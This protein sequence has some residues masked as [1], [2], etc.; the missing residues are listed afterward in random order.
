M[1]CS[2]ESAYIIDGLY[3]FGDVTAD[4]CRLVDLN[5]I[6]MD[7]L[8]DHTEA[9][10]LTT[11]TRR[12]ELETASTFKQ[13]GSPDAV[14]AALAGLLESDSQIR[15]MCLS[16]SLELVDSYCRKTGKSQGQ[17]LQTTHDFQ[18][19]QLSRRTDIRRS[20]NIQCVVNSER[21]SNWRARIDRQYAR[22]RQVLQTA[23][24]FAVFE[25]EVER[26]ASLAANRQAVWEAITQSR[27]DGLHLPI[28]PKPTRAPN[29]KRSTR[30]GRRALK[31]GIRLFAKLFGEQPI[32][33][34]LGGSEITISGCRY[35]YRVARSE[36]SLVQHSANPTQMHI[37]YRMKVVSKDGTLLA[38]GCVVFHDT[39]VI[40]QLIALSLHARDAESELALLRETNFFGHTTEFRC[41]KFLMELKGPP[42]GGLRLDLDPRDP[43]N[44][45]EARMDELHVK[46]RQLVDETYPAMFSAL[47]KSFQELPEEVFKLMAAPPF[48]LDEALDHGVNQLRRANHQKVLIHPALEQMLAEM[49]TA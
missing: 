20:D 2:A 8:V 16:A 33:A 32:K 49:S 30:R 6:D 29:I 22:A 41:D 19:L 37:P 17:W 10:P 40:D 12:I 9:E 23:D 24:F 18:N 28:E 47:A 27:S 1:P 5:V 44:D 42:D 34:F 48:R 31:K 36:T 15:E 25:K 39:P 11:L 7:N 14:Q 3:M 13:D 38:N 21:I 46:R 26:R 4:A 45:H 43:D 35:D